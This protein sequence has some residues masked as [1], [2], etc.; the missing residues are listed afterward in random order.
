VRRTHSA[1]I[2]AAL[3]TTGTV[4][5]LRAQPAPAPAIEA[6]ASER[7]ARYLLRNGLDYLVYP[8][9][10]GRALAFLREAEAHQ[11]ELNEAERQELRR[12]LERAQQGVRA[13]GPAA[14]PPPLMPQPGAIAPAPHTV[15][16]DLPRDPIRR[17]SGPATDS[18]AARP[19]PTAAP[20]GLTPPA[21]AEPPSLPPLPDEP[22][23]L[24]AAP[25]PPPALTER[26][27][28]PATRDEGPTESV[29]LPDLPPDA[30]TP[31]PSPPASPAVEAAGPPATAAE[32]MT[33]P[34]ISSTPAPAAT[35][36]APGAPPP[37]RVSD[38]QPGGRRPSSLTPDLLREVEQMAERQDRESRRVGPEGGPR[39]TLDEAEQP[40]TSRLDLPRAPSPTEARPIMAIPVP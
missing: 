33:L 37:D 15:R 21:P 32:E 30:P 25:E 6:M 34:P 31:L 22:G 19:F 12:G 5:V 39:D 13:A 14:I 26:P 23:G 40:S 24:P 16:L 18:A 20:P 4:S 1:A 11:A 27:I 35:G 17:T 2:A 36:S 8:E 29:T 28:E 9:Q 38:L 3:V 7:G 10:Q